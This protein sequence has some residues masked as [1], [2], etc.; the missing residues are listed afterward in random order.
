MSKEDMPTPEQFG[1][2]SKDSFDGDKSGWLF[3]GGEESYEEALKE[4]KLKQDE[5]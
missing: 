4:W 2:E 3:E 5:L 1:Y